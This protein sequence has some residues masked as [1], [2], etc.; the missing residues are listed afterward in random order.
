MSSPSHIAA[1][2]TKFGA[3]GP[4]YCYNPGQAT[5]TCSGCGWDGPAPLGCL[6]AVCWQL[7]NRNCGN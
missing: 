1:S 2:P 6:G 7:T 4:G 5:A 3:V